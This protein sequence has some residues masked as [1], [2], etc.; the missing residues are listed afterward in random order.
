MHVIR[1]KWGRL[2]FGRLQLSARVPTL[3]AKSINTIFTPLVLLTEVFHVF[4]QL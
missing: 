4:S 2:G 1:L 3:Y